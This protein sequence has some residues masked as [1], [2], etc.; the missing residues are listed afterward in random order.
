MCAGRFILSVRF[1][2]AQTRQMFN[3]ETAVAQR[4]CQVWAWA[5]PCLRLVVKKLFWWNR[6][7]TLSP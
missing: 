1:W 4:A 2:G 6:I 5:D 3:I 7:A